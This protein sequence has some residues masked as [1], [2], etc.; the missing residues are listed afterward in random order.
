MI[1]LIKIRN[2]H[3]IDV[4][5]ILKSNYGKISICQNS[6]HTYFNFKNDWGTGNYTDFPYGDILTAFQQL[7]GDLNEDISDYKVTNLEFG[8]NIR[9]SLS[10]KQML[11]NNFLMFNFDEFNQHYTFKKKGSYK[12]YNRNE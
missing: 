3:V 2:I 6:I 4:L 12:Q 5:K 10:P 1:I 7:Q 9:T 8:L 11:E